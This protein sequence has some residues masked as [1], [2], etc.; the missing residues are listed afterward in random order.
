MGEKEKMKKQ[1]LTYEESKKSIQKFHLI[2]NKEW[3]IFTKSENFPQNIPTN[4][5][6]IYKN[7]GWI[8]WGDF[9]DTGRI[10]NSSKIFKSFD[11][12]KKIVNQKNLKNNLEWRKF[13]LSKQFPSGIPATPDQVYKNKGWTS[14]EDWLGIRTD[15]RK[16]TFINYKNAKRKLRKFKISNSKEWQ[17]FAKSGK[18]P[19]DVPADAARYYKNKG[20]ISWGD[21]LS[22]NNIANQN[23]KYRSF[24]E[25]KKFVRSL[26]LKNQKEWRDYCNSG[27]KPEDIPTS[28]EKVYSEWKNEK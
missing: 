14:W 25:A 24:N 8:S 23:K 13:T 12:A 7:N 16:I 10:S 17:K 2:N 3:R 4:P 28:P 20:W 27:Q 21:F 1:F 6:K 9:L 19:E 22:T 18:K 15:P 11:E 26:G 5:D